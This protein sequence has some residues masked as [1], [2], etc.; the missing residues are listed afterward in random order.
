MMFGR[1][2]IRFMLA[3]IAVLG[4]TVGASGKV[5]CIADG[6]TAIED[7]S[8]A[9]QDCESS[10]GTCI[11]M[12]LKLEPL[13]NLESS[14]CK[15]PDKNHTKCCKSLF[16]EESVIPRAPPHTFAFSIP[17]DKHI[18]PSSLLG[19]RTIVLLN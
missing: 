15:N 19:L 18:I 8:E 4:L 16:V 6:H 10:C 14:T 2:T 13:V 1:V 9:D 17:R 3:F 11:D 12:P 5:L 7:I